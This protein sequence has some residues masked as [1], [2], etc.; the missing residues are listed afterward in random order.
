MFIDKYIHIYSPF[1]FG[2]ELFLLSG[3]F[4]IR[5]NLFTLCL[6]TN[7]F[8]TSSTCFPLN[9]LLS[10]TQSGKNTLNL[11]MHLKCI[12]MNLLFGLWD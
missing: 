8:S 9:G 10:M 7:N 11:Y 12:R 1:I 3:S 5:V 6:Q 4:P 2:S